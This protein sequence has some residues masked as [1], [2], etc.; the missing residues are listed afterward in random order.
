MNYIIYALVVVMT[1]SCLNN[2]Q[3]DHTNRKSD[4]LISISLDSVEKEMSFSDTLNFLE[5]ENEGLTLGLTY[6]GFNNQFVKKIIENGDVDAYKSLKDNL[7]GDYDILPYSILMSYKYNLPEAYT[8][9]YLSLLFQNIGLMRAEDPYGDRMSLDFLCDK[10]RKL[11]LKSLVKAY[12]KG[13]R[14]AA[15]YLYFYYKEGKYFPKDIL[16][17]QRLYKFYKEGQ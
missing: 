7:M 9:V 12:K 8:D 2:K 14:Q 11:A 16:Y 17:S 5:I 15:L 13:E 4:D 3:V 6:G 10:E 1:F